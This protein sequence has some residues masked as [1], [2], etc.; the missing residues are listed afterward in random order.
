MVELFHIGV[1]I[2]RPRRTAHYVAAYCVY[3]RMGCDAD[4]QYA[5]ACVAL[6][7]NISQKLVPMRPIRYG[8]RA[9]YLLNVGNLFT[10]TCYKVNRSLQ[11][12]VFYLTQLWGA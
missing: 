3:E 2:L 10:L 7:F 11:T 4:H 1:R 12:F 5:A 8:H 9:Y 6:H